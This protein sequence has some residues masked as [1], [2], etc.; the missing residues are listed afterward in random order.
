MDEFLT[1]IALVFVIEGIIPF[2]HPSGLRRM[3]MAIVGI[4]D[5]Q[6]RFAGLVSMVFGLL[7]LYLVR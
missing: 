6:L 3:S 7:L 5:G 4:G 1:A 2:C